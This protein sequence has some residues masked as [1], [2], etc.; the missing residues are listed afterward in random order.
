MI[1][2]IVSCCCSCIPPL[3]LNRVGHPA[4][5]DTGGTGQT[6]SATGPGQREGQG[7]EP[8]GAWWRQSH[9]G[10]PPASSHLYYRLHTGR[11]GGAH[12]ALRGK[13]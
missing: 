3:A 1:L 9:G 12:A 10:G 11:E 4:G 7:A 13:I 6:P 5:P 2:Y 8:Q